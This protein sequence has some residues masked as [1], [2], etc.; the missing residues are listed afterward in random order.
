MIVEPRRPGFNSPKR[1]TN[2]V[3]LIVLLK[4]LAVPGPVIA[5]AA[6]LLVRFKRSREDRGSAKAQ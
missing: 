1:G 6:V 4:K 3:M 2:L 5:G